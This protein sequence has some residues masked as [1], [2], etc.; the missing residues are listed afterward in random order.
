MLPS[1][2]RHGIL[3]RSCQRS[4]SLRSRPGS[5]RA[6]GSSTSGL[7]VRRLGGS[8][9]PCVLP[10]LHFVVQC[11]AVRIVRY[12][13]IGA[14]G[15]PGD[16]YC[17][18]AMFEN[19]FTNFNKRI[20][21]KR[22]VCLLT[23]L[24]FLA[25]FCRL[26]AP[27][28]YSGTLNLPPRPGDGTDYD[29]IGY[30]L[31]KGNGF[32]V[33]WRDNGYRAPYIAHNDK[34]SYGS[35]LSETRSGPTAYRPPMLPVIIAVSHIL[36]ERQFWPIRIVNIAFV[37][38]AASVTFFGISKQFGSL[39]GIIG[40]IYLLSQPS[41]RNCSREI[42]TDAGALLL[43]TVLLFPLYKLIKD[44]EHRHAI[45]LGLLL[46]LTFL[47]RT[48]YALLAP[49]IFIA[50]FFIPRNGVGCALQKSKLAGTF[51]LSFLVVG[52][53]WMIRNSIILGGFQPLGSQGSVNLVAAYSDIAVKHK[54]VWFQ[55][56][57]VRVFESLEIPTNATELEWE[58]E[59]GKLAFS[60][61]KKWMHENFYKVPLLFAYRI[62]SLWESGT[63]AMVLFFAALGLVILYFANFEFA[64][65]ISLLLLS[66]TAAI[67]LTW[68]VGDGR[69]LIPLQGL[70]SFLLATGVWA[71][72]IAVIGSALPQLGGKD[73]GF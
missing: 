21:R 58:K 16:T 33:D 30:E 8:T 52:G 45:I 18:H 12:L 26:I 42:L 40:A 68:V 35:V 34:G 37:A 4:W 46:G 22:F 17:M 7:A 71:F 36:F 70:L 53:P 47:C 28:L 49:F 54:G 65:A 50:I 55:S 13:C 29:A 32:A 66:Y 67:G 31:Y 9:I 59:V 6:P 57:D 2:L 25:S 20:S 73:R 38:L 23:L 41:V 56:K 61:T 63:S 62:R 72:L 15:F 48:I 10:N 27:A 51:L 44:K 3:P 14:A 60:M 39:P 64:L 19:E 1:S 69:F 11:P 24:V 5:E 43:T